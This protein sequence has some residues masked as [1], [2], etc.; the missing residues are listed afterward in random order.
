MAA[1]DAPVDLTIARCQGVPDGLS[2]IK[3]KECTNVSQWWWLPT[4][5]GKPHPRLH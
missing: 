2:Y 4:Y 3:L 5:I 1:F